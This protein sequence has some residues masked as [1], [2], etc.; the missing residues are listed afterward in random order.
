[1][2]VP[3]NGITECRNGED[4]ECELHYLVPYGVLGTFF[5]LTLAVWCLI[6]YIVRKTVTPSPKED[7]SKEKFYDLVGDQLADLKVSCYEYLFT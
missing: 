1:M 5:R 3:C 4:E 6:Q 2:A 7:Y